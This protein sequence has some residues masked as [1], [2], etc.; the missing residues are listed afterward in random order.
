MMLAEESSAG[1]SC[2]GRDAENIN[3]ASATK[4]AEILTAAP[5]SAGVTANDDRI[6]STRDRW[7][8]LEY[9]L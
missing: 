8:T 1:A 4:E 9:G 6:S 2:A 5:T 3:A 7:I